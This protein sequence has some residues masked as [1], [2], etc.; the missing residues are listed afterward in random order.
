M[1]WLHREIMNSRTYQLSWKPNRTNRDDDH[2]F[3]RA[4]PRR[5]PAEV[6]WDIVSQAASNNERNLAFV[7]NMQNRAVAVPGSG[8]RR[9]GK[10]PHAYPLSIFG[11][12]VRESNCDCDRSDDPSLLQTIFMRNDSQLLALLDSK[13]SWLAEVAA[14]NNIHFQPKTAPNAQKSRQQQKQRT[15]T[16]K[17]IKELLSRR[18]ARL[19]KLKAAGDKPKQVVSVEKQIALLN[20]RLVKFTPAPQIDNTIAP[21]AEAVGT[22]DINRTIEEAYLRTL[23]R[24]PTESEASKAAQFVHEQENQIDGLRDVMWALLNTKEFIVNH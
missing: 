12:S 20:S 17:K 9:R 21:E 11:R 19:A 8:S 18:E 5:L 24:K 22:I 14:D 1:K 3:A 7:S 13:N 15:Q 4:I 10:N 23:S 2:N 16:K 6:S